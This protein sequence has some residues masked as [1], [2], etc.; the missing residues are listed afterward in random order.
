[1]VR[2]A[3]TLSE[4]PP[5]PLSSTAQLAA[6][7]RVATGANNVGDER[8]P[9]DIA[10]SLEEPTVIIPGDGR[11]AW[12]AEELAPRRPSCRPRSKSSV[13]PVTRCQEI[14]HDEICNV[15]T[16]SLTGRKIEEEAAKIRLIV[17]SSA[18]A[19]KLANE[20]ANRSAGQDGWPT[21]PRGTNVSRSMT[22]ELSKSSAFNSAGVNVTYWLR[23]Y[24]YPLT[25]SSFSIPRR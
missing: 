1:M 16:Q 20:R 23:S 11:G 2:V 3:A 21:S 8:L 7:D 15:T 14:V 18:A 17:A 10:D 24:S 19:R 25:T 12:K 5:G 4:R 22:L 6:G 9:S 13:V